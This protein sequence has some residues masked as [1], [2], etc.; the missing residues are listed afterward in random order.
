[1]SRIA[2]ITGQTATGKTS[3]AIHRAQNSSAEIISADSRQVYEKL[4]IITGKD[5]SLDTW[6]L[7]TEND[8]FRVGYFVEQGIKIWGYDIVDPKAPF[9]SYDFVQYINFILRNTIQPGV[10]P[11]V[12]GGAYLYIQ[13]LIYGIDTT[14]GA[15]WNLRKQLESHS[16][17][18]LQQMLMDI[19]PNTYDNLNNSDRQN[20]HRLIR[21]IELAQNGQ[22]KQKTPIQPTHEV[23]S[24]E[25]LHFS[26]KDIMEARI[27]ERVH[28]RIEQ[29]AFQEVENLLAQGYTAKDPGLKTPGYSQIIQY[30]AGTITREEALSQWITTEVQYA[31]RQWTFMK[32]NT[33]ISWKSA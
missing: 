3:Y 23:V 33:D 28:S 24:F 30:L 11:I 19:D 13:H 21:K 16:I 10:T 27:T 22:P 31:K 2:V 1:M 17:S 8:S 7:V 5:I 20:P 18:E 14:A 26:S 32:R 9:S 12:V 29:G 4:N 6:V 25:G 15:D